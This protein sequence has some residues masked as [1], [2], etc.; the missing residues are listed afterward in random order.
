[1]R[2]SKRSS[3]TTGWKPITASAPT[4]AIEQ[5]D[6]RLAYGAAEAHRRHRGHHREHRR[7]RPRSGRRPAAQ[8]GPV[9]DHRRYAEAQREGAEDDRPATGPRGEREGS[10]VDSAT[11]EAWSSH[12]GTD[13]AGRRRPGTR[14]R[15]APRPRR[16]R[17][18]A[19][20]AG[21]VAS[22]RR[23]GC[24]RLPRL[25]RRRA[26]RIELGL[27]TGRRRAARGRRA[28]LGACSR[29]LAAPP[30]GPAGQRSLSDALPGVR[31]GHAV[32]LSDPAGGWRATGWSSG[33]RSGPAA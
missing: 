23:P 14:D 17:A 10:A 8:R 33:P 19:Q 15:R 5:R 18:P 24:R 32:R 7:A 27:G 26:R 28:A 20:A 11:A 9:G 4:A 25:A 21:R 13:L 22:R 16:R 12:A 1:M 31:V 2:Y 3:D 6:Q 29:C 30:R